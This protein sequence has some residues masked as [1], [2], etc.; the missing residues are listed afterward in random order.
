MSTT[1]N[2]SYY[3]ICQHCIE[4][5]VN[6][7]SSHIQLKDLAKPFD[8]NETQL[9]KVFKQYVGVSPKQFQQAVL[10]NQSQ[11]LLKRTSL[12]DTSWDFKLSSPARLHDAYVHATAMS[13]G[14]FK[15]LG[16]KLTFNYCIEH[17][18]LG[19]MLAIS[20]DRGLFYLGFHEANTIEAIRKHVLSPYPQAQVCKQPT[21]SILGFD[22]ITCKKPIDLHIAATNFQLHVWQAL[23]AIPQGHTTSYQMIA[24]LI[25]KP[26]GARA[27]GQAIGKNPIAALIPCH[28]VIQQSGALSGYRWGTPTKQG[29]LAR[30]MAL[31]NPP[32]LA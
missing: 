2:A 8:I 24:N 28:R 6:Q 27:I 29:L 1:S 32:A 19:D 31:S 17:S 9:Q 23:L 7:P 25:D 5:L 21:G 10:V 15:S 20:T 3:S 30:E 22:P 11:N 26:K 16:D 4:T 13:P 12:L 18:V 14:E